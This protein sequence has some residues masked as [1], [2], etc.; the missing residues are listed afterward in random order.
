MSYKVTVRVKS[1]RDVREI[2]RYGV[3]VVKEIHI[4]TKTVTL[5]CDTADIARAIR[6][7][8]DVGKTGRKRNHNQS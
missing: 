2:T 8:F 1:L 5:T 6:R 3:A 4:P 7:R